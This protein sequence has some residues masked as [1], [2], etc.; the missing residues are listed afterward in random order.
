MQTGLK[1]S[2]LLINNRGRHAADVALICFSLCD[3]D[4]FEDVER[5]AMEAERYASDDF[6]AI[7]VGLQKDRL[8]D[9]V[10]SPAQIEDKMW[11][12][13]VE[14]REVSSKTGE[15]VPE[16]LEAIANVELKQK[17]DE[18]EE[19]EEERAGKCAIF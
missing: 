2:S 12:F 13:F 3:S 7:L 19:V 9:R 11:D 18:G 10:I 16:L 4:S 6:V 14:Y 17:E 1:L 5:W 8:E 15:G